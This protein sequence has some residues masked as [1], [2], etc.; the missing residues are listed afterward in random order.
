MWTGGGGMCED[1]GIFEGISEINT[2]TLV[3][4]S[5]TFPTRQR[6]YDRYYCTLTGESRLLLLYVHSPGIV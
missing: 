5:Y 6:E 4:E 1:K 2:A 3:Y